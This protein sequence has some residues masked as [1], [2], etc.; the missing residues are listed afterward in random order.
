[1]EINGK[2]MTN[3]FTTK[4]VLDGKEVKQRFEP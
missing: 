4:S 3:P 2:T 1:V